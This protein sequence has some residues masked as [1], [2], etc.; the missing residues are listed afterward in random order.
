[1][2]AAAIHQEHIDQMRYELKRP[3]LIM[4]A[5]KGLLACGYINVETC[6]KT[7]EACAIVSGVNDFDDMKK[8]KIAATSNAA[9]ELG[10]K[11]GDTG[12]SA[13]QKMR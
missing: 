7:G 12:E 4:K 13:L 6:N 9:A 8:A 11:V 1:M 5:P 10:I 2:D 3:L